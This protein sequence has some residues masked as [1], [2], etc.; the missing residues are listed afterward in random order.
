MVFTQA[1]TRAFFEEA[2][3]MG[4]PVRTIEQ[5]VNEGIMNVGDLEEFDKDS[6]K[7]IAENLRRPGGR[8]ADPNPAAA[9]G[10]TVPT[11][12]YVFGAKSQ[13]RLT[14]ATLAVRYYNAIGRELTPGCMQWNPVL[15]N[16]EQQWDALKERKDAS[17]DVALPTITRDLPIIKWAEAFTDYLNRI[18]GVR[19]APL[20]YVIRTQT[21]PPVACPPRAIDLPHT[22]EYGS[23]EA[24]LVARATHTHPIYREDNAALYYKLEEATCSTSYAASI[25][26]YQRA[27]NGRGAWEALVSQYAGNDK[28]ELEIKKQD[29]LLHTRVWKGQ[30]NFTLERFIAQHRNAY[31]MMTQCAAHVDFQLPNE[32]TRVGYLLEAIQCSDAGLQAAMASIK[33]DTGA[34]GKRN[35]FEA[36]AAHLLPYDPVAKRR[37]QNSNKRN[38]SSISDVQ[39]RTDVSAVEKPGIG[40]TGVHFRY[41]KAAEYKKLTKEQRDELR[42]HRNDKAATSNSDRKQTAR[43]QPNKKARFEVSVSKAVSDAVDNRLKELKKAAESQE[44]DR[45]SARAYILSVVNEAKEQA[46]VLSPK[47]TLPI[48]PPPVTLNS[49]LKASPRAKRE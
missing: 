20:A 13:K 49:I 16:F 6:I 46:Q 26:P 35:D 5:L 45:E 21:T 24:D 9:P 43:G 47:P 3:Q 39:V 34:N 30:N 2:N 12:P 19:M 22:A 1:Q 36:S 27:R 23:V 32:H 33:V 40:K 8:M 4:I 44:A 7:Q 48:A 38:I 41:Y 37:A 14:V 29:D 15:Q 31:M 28:W 25:K 11:T 10:A 18:I 17:D 42:K